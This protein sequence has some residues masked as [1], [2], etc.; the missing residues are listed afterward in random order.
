MSY[1]TPVVFLIFRRPELTAQVFEQIRAA[2]PAKLLVVADGPRNAEEV[3]LCQQ[4]REVTEQI[5]WDCEVLRNYSDINLGCRDRVSSGLTWAFE[6]VEEAIILED[7]CLPNPSFFFYCETLLNYYRHDERV[8]VISG[9]N[10]QDGQ[11]RNSYS[12]YFSKYNHCW[13]WATWRRAW[14]YWEFSPEKW[15]KFRDA[16]LMKFVS[17]NPDEEKYW[18]SKFNNLFLEEKP[19]SWAHAWTFA[20][21]S[22]GGLT[23]LPHVNLVSNI[24]FGSDGT[25]T[26]GKGKF[27]NM[28]NEEIGKI[29]H[30]PFVIRHREA[31]VYTFDYVF[32]GKIMRNADTVYANFCQSSFHLKQYVQKLLANF[33]NIWSV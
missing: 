32:G 4:A 12:Y 10:F 6:Q 23:V 13:G 8:M 20:C 22:Q 15:T 9:D 33:R 5:D 27:A 19:N 3:H 11:Q 14:K 2:K 17:D 18:T 29:S 7:D 16:G 30:P 21:W 26:Q 28:F 24:G 25:H 31:D 1:S